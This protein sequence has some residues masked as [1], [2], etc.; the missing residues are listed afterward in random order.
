MVSWIK[1][2]YVPGDSCWFVASMNPAAKSC[3]KAKLMLQNV[4]FVAYQFNSRKILFLI[5]RKDHKKNY[6]SDIFPLNSDN[7]N[8]EL[9]T[10][11]H[12][13]RRVFRSFDALRYQTMRK[14]FTHKLSVFS[15]SHTVFSLRRR[16]IWNLIF[17]K[18]K[19]S[20]FII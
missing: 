12:A 4:S 19:S 6:T 7:N 9:S 17:L 2:N 16:T 3:E 13:A 5:N 11:P 18:E 8:I 20:K 14:T 1:F 15:S 10:T